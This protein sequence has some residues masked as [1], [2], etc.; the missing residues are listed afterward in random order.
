[1]AASAIGGRRARADGRSLLGR[2]AG[3]DGG[4]RLAF[5]AELPGAKILR[6]GAFKPR[7]NPYTFQGLREE[8]LK[9]LRAAADRHGL[10]TVTEV[11]DRASLELVAEYADML[12]VGARNMYNTELLEG[13][14]QLGKPVLL[15]RGFMATLEEFLLSRRV[16]RLRRAT[17]RSFCASAASA[18]SSA[19]R[20][21]RWTSRP[22]RCS[23][24]RPRCR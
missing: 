8:G 11:L 23:S 19:G 24:R 17:T 20:A 3:A 18:R 16:H 9:I 5:V 13:V 6:G 21:T 22:S 14:G 4:D 7:T 12:Q 10:A 15:K 2:D 1:M